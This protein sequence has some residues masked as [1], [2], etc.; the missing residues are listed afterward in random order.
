MSGGALYYIKNVG[1]TAAPARATTD[2]HFS[3]PAFISRTEEPV[4]CAIIV[5]NLSICQSNSSKLENKD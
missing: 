1:D 4:L 5:K 2:I 3:M